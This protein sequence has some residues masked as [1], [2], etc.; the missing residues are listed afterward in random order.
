MYGKLVDGELV[1]APKEFIETVE[2]DGVSAEVRVI[3]FTDAFLRE[4]G[5]KKIIFSDSVSET[6]TED[7]DY[8][9]Q[10]ETT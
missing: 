6:Y 8:I 7:D 5:Y 10:G 1:Q 4:K 3:G 2:M 9:Y